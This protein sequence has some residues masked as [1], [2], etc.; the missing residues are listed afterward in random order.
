VCHDTAQRAPAAMV[1]VYGPNNGFGWKVN[2]VVALQSLA[3]PA[4]EEL[5]E[6]G[7]VA[8][9]LAGGL[10]LVFAGAYFALTAALETLVTRPLRTLATAAERASVGE[11]APAMPAGGATE[12]RTL[13]AAIERLR[14]S[15]AKSM[16]RLSD[17]AR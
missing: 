16:T 2:E 1:A 11:A 13:S 3:I 9:L 7:E 10:L 14:S 15:V 8:L 4:A 5:K 12:I 17:K 6:T